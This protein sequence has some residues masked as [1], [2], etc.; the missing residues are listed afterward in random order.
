M[1]STSSAFV[2]SVFTKTVWRPSAAI[3]SATSPTRA[4]VEVADGHVR[5]GFGQGQRVRPADALA[6]TGHKG[7]P[8]IESKEVQ[9]AHDAPPGW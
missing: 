1:A 4:L 7:H 2:T 9:H 3:S 5:T 6:G 8:S